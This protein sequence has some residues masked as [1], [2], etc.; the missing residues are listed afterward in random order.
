[1]NKNIDKKINRKKKKLTV[2]VLIFITAIFFIGATKTSI[3]NLKTIVVKG[4]KEITKDKIIMSSGIIVGEN[5][6]KIDLKNSKENL[7]LHPYIKDI[8]IKRKLPNKII[9]DI[10]EK[11]EIVAIKHMNFYTYLSHD[12]LILDIVPEKKDNN[13]PVVTELEIKDPSI[14]NKVEYK[15]SKQ[16]DNITSF[17]E[18]C[19]SSGLKQQIAFIKFDKGENI[20]IT[21]KS[22][23]EVAFGTL[24]KVKYKLNF[25]SNTLEDLEKKDIKA[26]NIYLN[27]GNDIIVEVVNS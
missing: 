16:G 24:N 4:N 3:F 11:E 10:K 25:L 20:T 13:T 5:I 19:I 1:M 18:E 2:I 14:G 23:V 6:F 15:T 9:I 8:S 17:F 12:G 27:K 7:L 26:K 21:L 22:G